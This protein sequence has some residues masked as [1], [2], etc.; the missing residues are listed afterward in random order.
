MKRTDQ[1]II[2]TK[3]EVLYNII[4]D[5]HSEICKVAD[6]KDNIP[7]QSL[8]VCREILIL[9]EMLKGVEPWQIKTE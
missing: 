7:E 6:G 2:T 9:R 8:K 4:V 1:I 5:I 3:T